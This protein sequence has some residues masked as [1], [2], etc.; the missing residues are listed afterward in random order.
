MAAN[1]PSHPGDADGEGCDDDRLAQA[2][3]RTVLAAATDDAPAFEGF[4]GH[5][6]FTYA[7]LD[8]VDQRTRR[9]GGQQSVRAQTAAISG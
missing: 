6:V 8:A 5:G 3:G 2:M 1:G 4:H 9:D 7:I